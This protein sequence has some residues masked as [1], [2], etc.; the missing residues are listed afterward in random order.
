MYQNHLENL[1]EA[2]I[3]QTVN[4]NQLWKLLSS[5]PTCGLQD[6]KLWLALGVSGARYSLE[7]LHEGAMV[8]YVLPKALENGANVI[9]NGKL[10]VELAGGSGMLHI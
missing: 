3:K 6:S 4:K 7:F 2:E 8:S 1:K 10:V 9:A 5:H